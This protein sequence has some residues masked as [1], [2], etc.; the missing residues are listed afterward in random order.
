MNEP[1]HAS[2]DSSAEPERVRP[3][4]PRRMDFPFGTHI[5]RRWYRR[6]FAMTHLV[7]G[8][9]LLFPA[10]ERFFVRSVRHFRDRV[11]ADAALWDQVRG[12]IAQEVRHGIEHERFFATLEAQGYDLSRFIERYES[13][14]YPW[15]E[16]TIPP[17]LCL[18]TTVA[19][20]HYTATLGDFALRSDVLD[21]AD[22]DVAALLRWHAA[23]EIE[24]K[25]VAWEVLQRVDPSLRTRWM[26]W[27]IA[28]AGL[29]GWWIVAVV[30]LA[31]QER[32]LAR[33]EPAPDGPGDE[34]AT[35]KR[36]LFEQAALRLL[37]GATMQFLR[38]GFHPD[39]VDNQALAVNYLASIGQA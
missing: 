6:S 4:R 11:D 33:R 17:H 29:F 2:V 31:T 24:H 30:M 39:E 15:F 36:V 18:A 1:R 12:F 3:I 28:T 25:A 5:P 35:L 16:R 26:G 19:L 37:T 23:E 8:L 34:A 27:A 10:G 9:N 22:P 38:R 13:E 21:P 32:E 20:E 14:F 7:N